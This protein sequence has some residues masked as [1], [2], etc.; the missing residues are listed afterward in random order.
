MKHILFLNATYIKKE[1]TLAAA[2]EMG[3]D[4]SVVGPELPGW[5]RPYVDQYIEANTYDREE[6]LS[7]LR[8]RHREKP[9]DGVITFWDR[10]VELVAH[11][12][13]DLG[14]PGCPPVAAQRARN[15]RLMRETLRKH[16]VPHPH[17][18]C[19]KGWS[20][21]CQAASS[22][23]FPLIYKP[24]GASSSKGV[25][26][27]TSADEIHT[28]YEMMQFY[29][30]PSRDRMFSFYSDEHLVEEFMCGPEVSVEGLVAGG[31]VS[32]VGI[33]EKL[34]TPDDFTEYQ[35][36]FPGRFPEPITQEIRATTE[37]AIRA[38]EI[39]NCGFHAELKLTES[40]PKIVEVNGRLG[41]DLITT[42]LLPLAMGVDIIRANLQM[43]LG[44]PFD[45]APK[46]NR[47]A[48]I[49]FMLA[50]R[51]GIVRAWRGTDVVADQPGVVEFAVEKP[52]GEEVLLPPHRF[53]D[54]RMCYVVAEG[55]STAEAIQNVE[56]ALAGVE[57]VI[58]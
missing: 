32:M 54:H 42:H 43:A 20:E 34:A 21:L 30:S 31:V 24:V 44:E 29:A 9:F 53:N 28:A 18:A 11:V 37:A 52:I 2:K 6:T 45:L 12:A 41:G 51:E 49:R 26:K 48:C 33:T 50:D 3:L 57:C 36:A 22:I 55:C 17:F 15:K 47:G 16:G 35:H 4:V 56:F 1:R 39:D 14:L 5:S 7:V 25:F 27:V 8:R 46:W 58:Q 13:A 10:D 23:G 19:V 38:M 40:G